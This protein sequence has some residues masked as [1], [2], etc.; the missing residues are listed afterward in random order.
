VQTER[1]DKKV[2]EAAGGLVWRDS[3][4]GP[5]LLIIHRPRY[6]DWT[7]PKGKR[8][9]GE[10]WQET[11]LR[12]VKEETGCAARLTGFAGAIGYA[13][14]GV[15]KVVLYWN[16]VPDGAFEL[17]AADTTEVD[18]PVWISGKNAAEKL[19]YPGEKQLVLEALERAGSGL[20]PQAGS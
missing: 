4:Q 3:P 9:K 16:M 15:P 13:A 6:D 18:Q 17:E 10:R 5:E 2:I 11:A 1:P 12:E 8:K 14:D 7:L 20:E 19:D